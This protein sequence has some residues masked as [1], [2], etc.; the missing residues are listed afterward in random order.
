MPTYGGYTG[1]D[2]RPPPTPPTIGGKN[3]IFLDPTFGSRILRVTDATTASGYALMPEDAGFFRTFNSDSTA[4]KLKSGDGNSWWIPFNGNTFQVGSAVS[5]AGINYNWEWSAINPDILYYLHGNQIAKYNKTTSTP[6]DIGGPSNGHTVQYH[7]AVAGADDWVCSAAGPGVQNTFTEIFCIKPDS[8]GTVKLIDIVA[9]TINGVDFSSDT[10]WPT[11]TSIGIHSLF[12]SVVGQYL[13]V[14]FTNASW[15]ANG[16]AILDLVTNQWQRITTLAS[17]HSSIGNFRWY[18][19]NGNIAGTDSRGGVIRNPSAPDNTADHVHIMEPPTVDGFT[20][21]DHNSWFNSSLGTEEPLLSSRYNIT[22]PATK[23]AWYGEIILAETTGSNVVRRFAHNHNGGNL[24]YYASSFAQ[25]SND[26]KW[27]AFSSYWDGTL[28]TIS[29]SL[30]FEGVSTRIDT[31]IVELAPSSASISTALLTWNANTEPDL[32]GYRAYWG[33][34][35]GNWT[36]TTD[37]GLVTSTTLPPSSFN[38]DGTWYF[39]IDAF[40]T[41]ANRSPQFTPNRSKRIIRTQ[42]KLKRRK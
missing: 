29:G 40:D 7:I 4:L 6:T 8:P 15:Q 28:G 33:M 27:A 14:I 20:D 35:P 32:A 21:D 34:V 41:S 9:K 38:S 10:Q 24:A 31:F 42:S 2:R 16:Y 22:T 3:T 5:L 1:T 39:T 18:N 30:G 17:G 37:L 12:G 11:G 13:G 23:P 25:I 26:G 19:G 36:S